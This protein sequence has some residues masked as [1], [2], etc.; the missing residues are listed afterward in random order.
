[1]TFA[2]RADHEEVKQSVMLFDKFCLR[3]IYFHDEMY[4][5]LLK[6]LTR[7]FHSTGI[8]NVSLEIQSLDMIF[9]IEIILR[10]INCQIF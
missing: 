2:D 1:M 5:V 9:T 7:C 4:L 6:R 10:T 3:M 8:K